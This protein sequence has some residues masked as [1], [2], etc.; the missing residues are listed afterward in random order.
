[1]NCPRCK[2]DFCWTCMRDKR[3]HNTR[4]AMCPREYL[5]F[6]LCVNLLLVFVSIILMP[7]I[8]VIG[9]VIGAFV[10]TGY[11]FEGMRTCCSGSYRHRRRNCCE[12]FWLIIFALIITLGIVLPGCLALAGL[13]SAVL[14]SFGTIFFLYQSLVYIGT[15]SYYLITK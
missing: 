13:A 11:A 9:P 15:I 4:Y 2:Y 3:R 7:L 1:M 12:K 5:R 6:S 14:L 8:F 10:A